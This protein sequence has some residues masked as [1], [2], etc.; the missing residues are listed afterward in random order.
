MKNFLKFFLV[1]VLALSFLPTVSAQTSVQ[2][3][4]IDPQGD[5]SCLNLT[6]N[7]RYRDNDAKTNGQVSDLQDFLASQG[8]L[9]T[10]PTGYFGLA[11]FGAVKKFQRQ[12][13][14][15]PTGFVGVLTRGK[16]RD[17]TC[18]IGP[19]IS[20]QPTITVSSPISTTYPV[21]SVLP[22][23]WQTNNFEGLNIDLDLVNQFGSVVKNIAKNIPNT[24]SY[25]FTLTQDLY[26]TQWKIL[27]SSSDKGPSAQTY[28]PYFSVIAS[29]IQPSITVLSPN[30]GENW[31]MNTSQTIKW[32][33]SNLSGNIAIHLKDA[34][35]SMCLLSTVPVAQ[36]FYTFN[37]NENY[38]CPQQVPNFQT[39]KSGQYKISIYPENILPNDSS[40]TYF[41]ISSA[42][43]PTQSSITVLSPNGGE[44]LKKDQIQ[45]ISWKSTGISTVNILLLATKNGVNSQGLL[46]TQIPA[47]QGSYSWKIGDLD[48][49]GVSYKVK[50]I[51]VG[52]LPPDSSY[53][54]D[55]SDS[56]FTIASVRPII[57]A[58]K[59]TSLSAENVSAGT[60][61]KLYTSGLPVAKNNPQYFIEFN[62]KQDTPATIDSNGT[63]TFKV[64]ANY[65]A[66]TYTVKASVYGVDSNIYPTEAG[67]ALTI[68]SLLLTITPANITMTDAEIIA[69]IEQAIRNKPHGPLNPATDTDFDLDND[70]LV[71]GRDVSIIRAI[72]TVSDSVFDLAYKRIVSITNSQIG[73]TKSDSGFIDE[74]DVD[75]N[76]IIS[77]Q[78][79]IEILRVITGNRVYP[80]VVQYPITFN[81]SPVVPDQNI[82]VNVPNQILG[83]FEVNNT[84]NE[85]VQINKIAFTV[86]VSGNGGVAE[87]ITNVS[88]LNSIGMT[89][90]GPVDVRV[91]DLTISFSDTFIAPT[92][93]NTFYIKGKL[94]SKFVSGQTVYLYL[95]EIGFPKG[96]TTG[97]DYVLS[98]QIFTLSKMTARTASLNVS[99]GNTPVTQ[100][101]TAGSMGI[102]FTNFQLDATQSS[103]D[104]RISSIPTHLTYTSGA[105]TDINTC[106]IYE[107]SFP[108]STNIVNPASNTIPTPYVFTLSNPLTIPKGSIKTITL[109][110]NTSN[111]ATSFV[112]HWD[113][114]PSDVSNL[115]A[116]GGSS[117]L[118]IIPIGSAIGNNITINAPVVITTIDA[119]IIAKLEQAAR[120]RTK[121]LLNPA[122]DTDFDMN[123]DRQVNAT[124]QILIRSIKTI[125][126][127]KFDIAYK[128]IVK[129]LDSQINKTKSDATFIAELDANHDNVITE[130]DKSSILKA[131]IGDRI[132][133]PAQ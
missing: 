31:Q 26:A 45:T 97:K 41:T 80:A 14:F 1:T 122:T 32:N 57:Q 101:I 124:D 60:E 47:N 114:L 8:F 20:N 110:C 133:T 98:A 25:N 62:D 48:S 13:E 103:E 75:R 58:F 117:A 106:A 17:I 40:D 56:S 121:S 67:R 53:A 81:N 59:V 44:T 3:G 128:R 83:G 27:V 52:A 107:M 120:N 91:S 86:K 130:T 93:K 112:G 21:G 77:T 87:E 37:L 82:S 23:R 4:D 7:L 30:G 33:Y 5:T 73:K 94:G 50:I 72:Q 65:S 79:K 116:I 119:E 19:V 38:K 92:G 125:V 12:Y 64:P 10:N 54:E 29:T 115:S 69:N 102:A 16:I 49:D 63:F 123:N 70:K 24:G 111:S 42:S 18:N 6:M 108:L 100:T 35:G 109:R 71:G 15:S 95:P 39:I 61:V 76:G 9:N 51:S 43:S 90:A 131:I 46:A 36:G 2:N 22:I 118:K 99:A 104:V 85:P 88:L 66:G 34:G 129:I 74:L 11:T 113:I 105:G 132:Y 78:D 28:S 126:D 68:N 55:Y 84:T 96:V 89:V 127:D